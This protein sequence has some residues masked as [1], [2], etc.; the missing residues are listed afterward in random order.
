MAAET[1]VLDTPIG[2]VYLDW[3]GEALV[4]VRLGDGPRQRPAS[5]NVAGASLPV[6]ASTLVDRLARYFEGENVVLPRPDLL[7]FTPFQQDAWS[8]TADVK[9]GEQISYGGLARALGRPDAARAVGVAL[10]QNPF[11]PLIPCH[12]VIA[13]SGELTGFAFGLA[14]K[15]GLLSLEARQM[16]LF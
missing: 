4:E 12:R 3:M 14:W 13:A 15:R 8:A 10:G 1:I 6:P 16:T 11:P 9:F 2:P 5:P 7:S